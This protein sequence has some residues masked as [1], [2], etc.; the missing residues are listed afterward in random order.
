M[1]KA[2]PFLLAAALVAAACGK[3]ALDSTTPG[4]TASSSPADQAFATFAE[5]YY[6]AHFDFRPDA[7]VE[8]GW[9]KYDGA[10][11]DRSPGAVKQEIERLHAAAASL[12]S[13]D[14]AQLSQLHQLERQVLIYLTRSERF[15]LEEL[16]A[17]HRNPASYL[18]AVSPAP[19]IVRDYAPVAQRA[20]AIIAETRALPGYLDLARA[21]VPKVVPRT[22]LELAILQ[23]NGTEEFFR[24]DVRTALA[25][26]LGDPALEKEFSAALDGAAA[27]LQ[28]HAAYLVEQRPL[29]TDDFALG[30]KR[31][32]DM[33][34]DTQG[35]RMD[36]AA[37][38]KIAQADLE[39]NTRAM[40]A[41]AHEIDPKKPVRDV[42]LALADEGKPSAAGV[43][44]LA[45]TQ[46]KDLR[47]FLID[48]KIVT[49]PSTDVA[50]VRES[51]PFQR[52]N[53]AF[54]DG[55]GT[56]DPEGLPSYYYIS[57]PDP[58]WP[59]A[60]QRA[61]IPP[62][63][64]LL[65]ITVHEVWPGHFLH[66]LHIKK[67]ASRV[68]KSFCTYSMS[69]GWA[70]Y[71]EEMMYDVGA[72]GSDA[73]AHVGQLKEAL[74]RNVRFL[75][76]IGE[77]AHGMTVEQA[78]KMFQDKAFVDPGNARQQAVR[79][80]FDPMFL[81]YTVGKLMIMKLRED[82]KARQGAAY[83]LGGFHDAF[84]SFACAPIPL[85]REE[86]LGPGAG[87]AL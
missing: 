66:H 19:Y 65:Y 72:T 61:Y 41:A 78:T 74:L 54:L 44:P 84:L 52:W 48:H 1:L 3:P 26:K 33:L 83:T 51:P 58:K 17:V 63:R 21:N 82:Y 24:V 80:T 18:G 29:A 86:L 45:T 60:E 67:N 71:A 56:F 20:R 37:L 31:L 81:S 55:A 27:A 12:D 36:L 2:R 62:A 9:H 70:H 50:E 53:A 4:G 11:P 8:L 68:L 76:A 69:E 46:V 15:N 14:V 5:T 16:D 25:G 38:E 30:E 34:A 32:L 59:E 7:A 23:T 85:I 13:M 10:L 43:L 22:W 77:H 28:A 40:E 49:V 42:V 75:V 87:N 35:V 64:D 79:G 6:W 73:R 57:P 47:Q 39:R